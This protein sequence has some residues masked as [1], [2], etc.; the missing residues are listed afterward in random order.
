MEL[1]KLRDYKDK[2]EFLLKQ[3]ELVPPKLHMQGDWVPGSLDG[4][5]AKL[6]KAAQK[7]VD[8]ATSPV[9]IGVM[10]EFSSGKTL[11]LGCLIGY[12]DSLPVSE[13]PTT[14]NVTAI[15]LIP[16][17]GFKTTQVDDYTVS[18]LTDDEVNECLQ[19]MLA[20]ADR[21]AKAV[22]LTKAPQASLNSDN[23]IQWCE[24]S[25]NSSK[26]LELRYLLRELVI[27]IRAHIAYGKA[28]CGRSYL[29]GADTAREG[30]KLPE[31]PM[32]I[33]NFS[34]QELPK[35]PISLPNAPQTLP[36]RLMQNTFPLIKRVDIQV[37]I[38]KDIW[39]ISTDQGL[40][41][42]IL[43]DF[44]GLGTANS[45]VRDRYLSLKELKD[46]QTVLLLLNGKSTGSDRANEIFTMMQQ[47]RPGQDLKD[48]ILV[49][50]GRFNQLPLESEGGERELDKLVDN[51]ESILE[52][53]VL[54]K[55]NVL[56]TTIDQASAF[57][58]QKERIIFLDQLMGIADLA[59]RSSN[60][61]VASPDFLANL[62]YPGFLDLS[63]RM[64]DKWGKLSQNLQTS[65][66]RSTLGKQLGYFASDG[67]IGRLR[68]L[69]QTH[70]S[71]HGQ[72][73]LYEDTTRAYEAL[74]KQQQE[75]KAELAK[76]EEQGI[77]IKESQA[78]NDL[79]STIQTLDKIYRNFQRNL[80][81]EP[82]KNRAG[83]SVAEAV[84]EE[85]IF[86]VINWNEWTLLF[87]KANNGIITVT[88]SKGVAGKLFDRGNKATSSIPNKSEEFYPIF[89]K[90]I[91]ELE[92]FAGERIRQ[93][94]VDLLN[95]LSYE[96]A[97]QR[98]ELQGILSLEQKDE[99]EQDIEAKFGAE[100][101]ELFYRLTI[102]CDPKLWLE[103]IIS[104]IDSVDQRLVPKTIFPLASPDD[105]HSTGTIFYWS[106]K[107]NQI[108]STPANQQMLVLRL[109]DEITAGASLHLVQYVSEVNQR[110]N[111]ELA[112]ILG[113]II[114]TLQNISKK[115]AL[116]R[117]LADKESPQE[118]A[119]P[120]WLKILSEIAI[121][122]SCTDAINRVSTPN[123]S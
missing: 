52:T 114:P 33:Q 119:I 47:E 75:L 97:P 91:Q 27:F 28:M 46:V 7:T 69:I 70:A 38:S 31:M 12:A 106:L 16:Q 56:R 95:Q 26:N 22:G 87:N 39:D 110:V 43:L 71:T 86:K 18:Y 1:D 61:T 57:T 29:I 15:H 104:D 78:L 93:A 8:L 105:K 4:C 17:A 19:F 20:E 65:D 63:K 118:A 96:V 89:E 67:G 13:N 112:G 88:E 102:G 3:L 64:R 50:I 37:K 82:L 58:T 84:K 51:S 122:N 40:S 42:F 123:F 23:I 54:E 30:L 34:F 49:G 5:I 21:R 116:L 45:G 92:S 11:L 76:I 2:G 100:A 74:C 66:P 121:P 103:A 85:L 10:G 48:L 59:K 41:Q 83:I 44:P 107:P 6:R 73:Q 120:N 77:P 62:D 36:A 79:R 115:E 111:K 9:K 55:L 68:E 99:L 109:R 80:G 35:A 24:E 60:V 94:V 25:W 72:R 81:K 113:E 108:K 90:T 32:A 14:G 53:D 98:S 117:Y 101:A